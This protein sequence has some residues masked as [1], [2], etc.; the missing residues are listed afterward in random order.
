VPA[1]GIIKA[2]K[3]CSLNYFGSRVGVVRSWVLG[4]GIKAEALAASDSVPG[5]L[6]VTG[7]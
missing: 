1:S 2:L 7:G 3:R 5:H 4:G 6:F